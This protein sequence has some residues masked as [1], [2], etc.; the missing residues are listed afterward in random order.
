[1]S[2]ECEWGGTDS[3]VRY[4]RVAGREEF[5]RETKIATPTFPDLERA[6]RIWQRRQVKKIKTTSRPGTHPND[7]K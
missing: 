4:F 1:M 3:C 5:T 6:Y 2:E 7:E